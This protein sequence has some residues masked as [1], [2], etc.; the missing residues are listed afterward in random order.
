MVAVMT[1]GQV[2]LPVAAGDY[3]LEVGSGLPC[4][5]LFAH[6]GCEEN[7]F[8]P[9]GLPAT[10]TVVPGQLVTLEML[11][12]EAR[13]KFRLAQR[14]SIGASDL[15][16]LG[17]WVAR[18]DAP[19]MARTEAGAQRMV[20]IA[21]DASSP[22]P[23]PPA[24]MRDKLMV[25]IARLLREGRHRDVLPLFEQ[26]DQ[27][28]LPLDPDLDYYWG[29]SLAEAGQRDAA[30]ATLYR[31]IRQQGRTARHYRLALELIA[32]VEDS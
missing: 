22:D 25:D 24:V 19:S 28:P 4:D 12:D 11:F 26:L 23:L 13:Y 32:R 1:S 17:G 20:P 18:I 27:L 14:E 5:S 8:P 3:R 6:A 15:P 31:Y 29:Q 7:P 30:L 10:M 9:N 16:Q 21:S 2:T